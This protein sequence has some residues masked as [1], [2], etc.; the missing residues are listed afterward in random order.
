M[1]FMLKRVW[2][3]TGLKSGEFELQL[4]MEEHQFAHEFAQG[5][6]MKCLRIFN[7][8]GDKWATFQTYA[9]LLKICSF[10]SQMASSFIGINA[11][12][13]GGL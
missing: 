11:T 8:T 10:L 3:I 5:D 2:L 6:L 4:D 7:S 13:G 1:D 12:F 9:D